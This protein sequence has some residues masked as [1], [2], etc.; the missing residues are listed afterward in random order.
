MRCRLCGISLKVGRNW[1]NSSSRSWDYRCISCCSAQ[2][3]AYKLLHAISAKAYN[4]NYYRLHDAEI[5]ARVKSRYED[6][7]EA[8]L[9]SQR[10]YQERSKQKCVEKFGGECV[11]CGERELSFLT[12]GHLSEGDGAKHR[13]ETT[14]NSKYRGGTFYLSLL[15]GDLNQYPM[16]LECFNCNNAKRNVGDLRR[17]AIS[18]YGAGCRCC[19][20]SRIN[21]LTIGHPGNDG[22]EHRKSTGTEKTF[23]RHLKKMGYPAT[24][25]GFNIEVQCW[26]CNSGAE[27][28]RGVC[29]HK[30]SARVDARI[31]LPADTK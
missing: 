29:P 8:V 31:G 13:R 19:G 20:E 18:A 11:H 28:N 2:N 6:N 3:R 5:R 25:D 17:E 12:F 30:E 23:Y 9:E 22:G 7:R 27:A 24:P 1:W 14:G 4:A 10:R 21:R 26:N 16:Q 15:R